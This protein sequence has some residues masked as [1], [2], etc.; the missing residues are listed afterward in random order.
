MVEQAIIPEYDR[1]RLVFFKKNED[2]GEEESQSIKFYELNEDGTYTNGTTVEYL[3]KVAMERLEFL[4]S[5]FYSEYNSLAIHH[6]AEAFAQL[7]IRTADRVER[8]VEG[9]HQA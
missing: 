6:L 9:T 8:Q 3:I 4:N 5:K 7:Q 1:F 2:T